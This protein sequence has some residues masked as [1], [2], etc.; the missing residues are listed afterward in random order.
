MDKAPGLIDS[1]N[2][3]CDH[4]GDNW[5]AVLPIAN[6]GLPEVS[7]IKSKR[8]EMSLLLTVVMPDLQGDQF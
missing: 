7:L 2:K 5:D 6:T 3:V 8:F 1:A 4:E